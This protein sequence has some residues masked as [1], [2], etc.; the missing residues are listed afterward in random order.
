MQNSISA[1]NELSRRDHS[2]ERSTNEKNV[3]PHIFKKQTL[4]L[5]LHRFV[6]KKRLITI[7]NNE[8]RSIFFN[9]VSEEACLKVIKKISRFETKN[10]HVQTMDSC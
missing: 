2:S 6:Y 1:S 8:L 4:I 10:G 9:P 7:I 3:K 5:I